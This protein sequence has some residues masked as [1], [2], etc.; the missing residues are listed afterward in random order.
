MTG[1]KPSGMLERPN[2]EK[3]EISKIRRRSKM[4]TGSRVVTT[5]RCWR[6]RNDFKNW[7]KLTVRYSN[8]AGN[9]STTEINTLKIVLSSGVKY[10]GKRYSRYSVNFTRDR[11]SVATV[12]DET[13]VAT[14]KISVPKY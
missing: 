2:G 11:E 4:H 3:L 5:C 13:T 1:K 8:A 6:A 14:M 9:Y 7:I 12:V 10:L